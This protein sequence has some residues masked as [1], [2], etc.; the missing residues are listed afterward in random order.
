MT[1]LTSGPS[2]RSLRVPS[3]SAKAKRDGGRGQGREQ[4]LG[5]E[6]PVEMRLVSLEV[7]LP[8]GGGGCDQRHLRMLVEPIVERNGRPSTMRLQIG[9][10]QDVGRVQAALASAFRDVLERLVA[11]RKASIP[12]RAAAGARATGP[13]R[14]MRVVDEATRLLVAAHARQRHRGV[15]HVP[16]VDRLAEEVDEPSVL[17]AQ[18]RRDLVGDTGDFREG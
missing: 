6:V 18:A 15:A 5:L 14:S 11:T 12:R 17:L 7:A 9:L 8:H 16:A 2:R 3:Q 1:T 10:Q 13:E 4:A